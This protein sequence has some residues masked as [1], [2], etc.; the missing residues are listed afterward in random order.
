MSILKTIKARRSIRDYLPTPVPEE[1]LH[2]LVEAAAWAPSGSNA[3]LWTFVVVQKRENVHKLKTLSPGIIGEPAAMIVI[4]RDLERAKQLGIN[5]TES[6]TAWMSDGMAAQNIMLLAHE[7]GIGSCAVRSFHPKVVQLLRERKAG[8][9]LVILGG[10]I[11]P[12]DTPFLKEAGIAEVFGSGTKL[13]DIVD[14][15]KNNV[16]K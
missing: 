4:G 9:I 15:V 5:G 16:C 2:Q 3:Q 1:I 7:L 11:Q 10:F 14:F 13:Q 6:V 8:H 12:E